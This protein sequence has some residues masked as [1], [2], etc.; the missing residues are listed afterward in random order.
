M[1]KSSNAKVQALINALMED[2]DKQFKGVID[3]ISKQIDGF[4]NNHKEASK[5]LLNDLDSKLSSI[6]GLLV[7]GGEYNTTL[8]DALKKAQMNNPGI[9]FSN[10]INEEDLKDFHNSITEMINGKLDEMSLKSE[11]LKKEAKYV[12][13]LL[14]SNLSKYNMDKK[15]DS[16]LTNYKFTT[17]GQQSISTQPPYEIKSS[18]LNQ[19]NKNIDK[20]IK[21]CEDY[22]TML[23]QKIQ[24]IE[25]LQ[26]ILSANASSKSAEL[27][28]ANKKLDNIKKIH[29]ANL[30][31]ISR[32]GKNIESNLKKLDKM[33][34]FK[35]MFSQDAKV[36]KQEIKE[37]KSN[38][39]EF[40]N[41]L[42]KSQKELEKATEYKN[43][44]DLA[45]SDVYVENVRNQDLI[46]NYQRIKEK[47]KTIVENSIKMK[48]LIPQI[49]AYNNDIQTL[50]NLILEK[51]KELRQLPDNSPEKLKLGN[52][53]SQIIDDKT[54][55]I[56][57]LEALEKSYDDLNENVISG[58]KDIEEAQKSI[59]NIYKTSKDMSSA[60]HKSNVMV[61]QGAKILNHAINFFDKLVNVSLNIGL[62]IIGLGNNAPSIKLLNPIQKVIDRNNAIITNSKE[63]RD[64]D[65]Q[66]QKTNQKIKGIDLSI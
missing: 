3:S 43:D 64:T 49:D 4:E 52:E 65:K 38:I 57:E 21:L 36:L 12:K 8:E 6:T 35:K 54:G 50:T 5:K 51:Q 44:C 55:K 23:E 7:S 42:P 45:H 14:N 41:Q 37:A 46:N 16:L 31:E 33:N 15:L 29:Q 24:K 9:D 18:K 60:L 22:D 25:N 63:N 58:N 66:I 28:N 11:D 26:T 56:Q 59:D 39:K 34:F 17:L 13:D 1:L 19:I 2:D 53:I 10:G 47:T 62:S 48:N 30:D 27:D 61:E 32:N 20:K 40:K